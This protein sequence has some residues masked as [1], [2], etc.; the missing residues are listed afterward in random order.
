MQ[1]TRNMMVINGL[2]HTAASFIVSDSEN[3]K[4]GKFNEP[5]ADLS[6][7]NFAKSLAAHVG[8]FI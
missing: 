6:F 7:Y 8:A 2:V 3:G 5:A 1:Q 4:T